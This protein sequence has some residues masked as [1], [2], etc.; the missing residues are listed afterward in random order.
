VARVASTLLVLALLAGTAVAFAVT[1]SLKLVPSP[2]YGTQVDK[3]FSPACRCAD[4]SAT[5]S[6]RVRK[7]DRV[8]AVIVDGGG[9][10]VSRLGE[11]RAAARGK[12]EFVWDGLSDQG[13]IVPDGTYK[14]RIHLSRARRTILLPNPIL[15]DATPP[16][17]QL[18][19]VTPQTF[20]PDG[21]RRRDRL[22]ARYHA[23]EP[24]HAQL[25]VNA[26][27]RVRGKFLREEGT[28]TWY[29]RIRRR[30]VPAGT[31]RISVVAVDK[32]GNTSE[33]TG[34][35]FAHVRYVSLAP[36]VRVV[37]PAQRFGIRVATDAASYSYRFAGGRGTRS[38]RRL[39]LRAPGK[40]GF[41]TLFVD[42]RGH[43]A[44][45]TIAVRRRP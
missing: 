42:V 6:F 34:E 35:Y 26:R 9:A 23:S 31:Y 21:D 22:V 18:V 16:V 30:S 15:L 44:K 1:E 39:V 33:R 10:V 45:A 32:A 8:S 37:R 24:V 11:E 17:V 43:A 19:S 41:Y 28:L 29:G 38:G 12:V 14:P 25:F 13:G 36:K 40:P 7:A 2:V 4:P 3:V 5:I 27:R 20:S